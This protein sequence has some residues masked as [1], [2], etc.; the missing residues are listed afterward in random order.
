MFFQ[1]NCQD[2]YQSGQSGQNLFQSL[3]HR[4]IILNV[5]RRVIFE[6]EKGK[7]DGERAV[8]PGPEG[9]YPRRG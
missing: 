6:R 7:E 3:T 5:K 9:D 1:E 2:Y 4:R 8:K